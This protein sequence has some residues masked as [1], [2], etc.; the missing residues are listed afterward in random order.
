MVVFTA[1]DGPTR[2]ASM[3]GLNRRHAVRRCGRAAVEVD[4]AYE[5]MTSD[6]PIGRINLRLSR[7]LRREQASAGHLDDR[8][9]GEK[10]APR[11]AARQRS[12]RQPR[13]RPV[14][15]DQKQAGR[16]AVR[17]ER[18]DE[19]FV[20]IECR[21][22]ESLPRRVLRV[23]ASVERGSPRVDGS[24]N[25]GEAPETNPPGRS[26]RVPGRGPRGGGVSP[27]PSRGRMGRPEP[28][29]SA[30]PPRIPR[31]RA[32]LLVETDVERPAYS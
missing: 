18:S 3:R 4:I 13:D 24:R 11:L 21:V 23:R 9:V 19:T 16:A 27:R 22:I 14:G 12:E 25:R 20:D 10:I 8:H 17:P 7:R 1:A 30:G 6:L 29:E 31:P 2:R 26:F 32:L 28:A 15:R 5:E